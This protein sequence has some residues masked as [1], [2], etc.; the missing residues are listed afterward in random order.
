MCDPEVRWGQ[1]PACPPPQFKAYLHPPLCNCK[2]VPERWSDVTSYPSDEFM[3]A[4]RGNICFWSGSSKCAS[5]ST[6]A[7]NARWF[8][9]ICAEREGKETN[10]RLHTV[11]LA[12]FGP[13]VPIFHDGK[14]K[15]LRAKLWTVDADEGAAGTRWLSVN[16]VSLK[17][18][19]V[20]PVKW[21]WM[22][23]IVSG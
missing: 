3:A 9:Q 15:Q 12:N 10:A 18:F 21:G 17:V 7:T 4:R 14:K 19:L 16:A 22:Q 20:F 8:I 6:C 1:T 5:S 23:N 2:C 13:K 11:T